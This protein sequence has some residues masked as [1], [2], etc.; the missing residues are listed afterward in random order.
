MELEDTANNN[1]ITS[2]NNSRDEIVAMHDA[3]N[4]GDVVTTDVYSRGVSIE[5]DKFL[6][7]QL[8][9]KQGR[10]QWTSK[11]DFMLAT[12]GFAVDLGNVWRFP[13]VCYKNGGG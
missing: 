13:Y 1:K 5:S 3:I 2:R 6:V 10:E 9:T 12:I 7:R 11:F 8:S 4:S